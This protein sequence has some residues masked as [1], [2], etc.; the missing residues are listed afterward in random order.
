MRTREKY[1]RIIEGDDA[2][3]QYPSPPQGSGCIIGG[4]PADPGPRTPSLQTTLHLTTPLGPTTSHCTYSTSLYR[5][6][7]YK[8]EKYLG[9]SHTSVLQLTVVSMFKALV[10]I[11]VLQKIVFSC[12]VVQYI[13]HT[14]SIKH[15]TVIRQFLAYIKVKCALC[16]IEWY[17]AVKSRM[18]HGAWGSDSGLHDE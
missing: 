7:Y 14:Y 1:L 2:Y 16:T 4:Q 6:V 10:L 13:L 15:M 9:V 17:N 3:A 8:V 18:Q 11:Y 5:H 12:T